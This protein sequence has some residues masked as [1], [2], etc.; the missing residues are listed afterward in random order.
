MNIFESFSNS[1]DNDSKNNVSDAAPE[2]TTATAGT[3][4]VSNSD[5][6]QSAESHN[7]DLVKTSQ[8][9][10]QS[11]D[12]SNNAFNSNKFDAK[13]SPSSKDSLL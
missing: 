9:N 8:N 13:Q 7:V 2:N 12:S 1:D 6:K 3:N 10:F 5:G 11:G 4:D